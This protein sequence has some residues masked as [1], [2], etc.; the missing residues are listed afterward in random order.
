MD[1][2]C[3]NVAHR[4][5][6]PIRRKVPRRAA[7]LTNRLIELL[8]RTPEGLTRAELIAALYDVP[9]AIS[10]LR[11]ASL[12]ACVRKLVQRSRLIAR[13]RGQ[14]I[15]FNQVTRRWKVTVSLTHV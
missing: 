1:A 6:S 12:D 4:S 2:Q 3:P 14:R 10:S 13:A 5:E 8:S 11:Q 7:V 9:S 15:V